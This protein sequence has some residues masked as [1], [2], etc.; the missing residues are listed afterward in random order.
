MINR[1]L[2]REQVHT[3]VLKMIRSG[4]LAPGSRINES[5]LADELGVSR[6]PL[7]EALMA[8][9]QDHVLTSDAGRGFFVKPLSA[10]EFSEIVPIG[11]ALE[12]LGLQSAGIPTN[13]QLQKMEVINRDME[14]TSSGERLSRLD[15]KWHKALLNHCNN[16][17]LLEMIAGIRNQIRRYDY[18]LME[19]ENQAGKS[20]SQHR[21]IISLL[22]HNELAQAEE[23]LKENW[24]GSIAPVLIW[25]EKMQQNA[26]AV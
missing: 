1:N 6:T 23:V 12:C 24:M 18:A 21:K 9:E 13:A 20:I 3:E 26:K 8:L 17:Q 25:I 7:R 10:Q 14:K 2:L 19:Q 15:E 16:I 22:K 4:Q 5:R 11:A